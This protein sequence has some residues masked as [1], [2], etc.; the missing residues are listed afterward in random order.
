LKVNRCFRGTYRFHL[1]GW[2]VHQARNQHE[3]D[4][5]QNS[6]TPV[7]C[8]QTTWR[9]IPQDRTLHNH[10]CE[11]LKSYTFLAILVSFFIFI[12]LFF[13]T[14]WTRM[15][16]CLPLQLHLHGCISLLLQHCLI[17]R[18]SLMYI[19]KKVHCLFKERSQKSI[20]LPSVDDRTKYQYF[21]AQT[22]KLLRDVVQM[23]GQSGWPCLRDDVS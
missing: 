6:K 12:V 8:Q 19:D 17:F 23:F 11:N 9:Y 2:R 13:L 10:R 16:P 21:W 1:Q 20:I 7:D 22:L 4:S 5:K 18:S 14:P 15:T 3:A